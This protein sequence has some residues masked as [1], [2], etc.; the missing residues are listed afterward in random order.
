MPIVDTSDSPGFL[1]VALASAQFTK[2]MIEGHQ[3]VLMSTTAAWAAFGANPTASKA[4]GSVYLPPNVPIVIM[5]RGTA[6]KVAVIRDAADG[7]A[8]LMRLV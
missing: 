2:T 4:A 5:C 3:Y 6:T 8:S 7:S 1:A